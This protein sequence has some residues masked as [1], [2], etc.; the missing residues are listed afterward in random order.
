MSSTALAA[1]SL[2]IAT[3]AQ[4]AANEAKCATLV[5][6][7]AH[8]TATV[9]QRKE[10]A[11]CIDIMHPSPLT[12]GEVLFLKLVI[13]CAMIGAAIG[14]WPSQ[15]KDPAEYVLFG[16]LGVILGALVPPTCYG[17][18]TAIKFLFTA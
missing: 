10:Y 13:L 16:L 11:D 2:A 9:G 1:A 4:S 14:L 3:E 15:G 8:N 5:S 6:G 12:G 7:Y 18:I 17:I